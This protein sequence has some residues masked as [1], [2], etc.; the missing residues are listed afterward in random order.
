MESVAIHKVAMLPVRHGNEV[1]NCAILC[2]DRHSG[3]LVAVPAQDMGLKAEA[4]ARQ[5]I[6]HW[7][8]VFGTHKAIYSDNGSHFTS[9]WFRTMRQLMGVR[10]APTVA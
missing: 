7:R 1:Y 2:V 5:M 8:T 3:Y 4:V 6:S 10:H 9:A